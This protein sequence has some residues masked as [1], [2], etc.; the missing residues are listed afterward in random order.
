MKTKA[1]R[2]V[3]H[4]NALAMKKQSRRTQGANRTEII[5]SN[6]KVY[7]KVRTDGQDLF[8]PMTPDKE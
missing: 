8:V 6:N 1:E 4:R 2:K 7:L 5:S 3:L